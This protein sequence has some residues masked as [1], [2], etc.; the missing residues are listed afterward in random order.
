MKFD[1][2]F[3]DLLVTILGGMILTFLFFLFKEKIFP[4]ENINGK[5]Y[6]EISTLKTSYKPYENMKLRYEAIIYRYGNLIKGSAEKIYEI[7]SNNQREF[8][9][10]ERSRMIIEGY[11]EKKYFEKDKLMLY[12][13]EN[14]KKRNSTHYQE[15]AIESDK[16]MSGVFYSTIAEQYGNV[17]W[18]R[19]KF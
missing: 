17:R 13:I 9:G 15:L 6:F 7:T 5:W 18:Q 4:L 12:I 8:I 16:K 11:I 19:G 1:T 10:E 14:G 2:F 3:P